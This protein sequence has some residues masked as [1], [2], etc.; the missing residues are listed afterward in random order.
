MKTYAYVVYDKTDKNFDKPFVGIHLNEVDAQ[1]HVE[2]LT[3]DLPTH[4]KGLVYYGTVELGKDLS[5]D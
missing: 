2:K 4:A 3:K 1:T 5:I